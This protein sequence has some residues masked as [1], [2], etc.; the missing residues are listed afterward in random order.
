MRSVTLLKVIMLSVVIFRDIML[1][2]ERLNVVILSVV[3]PSVAASQARTSPKFRLKGE[4]P[5][6]RPQESGRIY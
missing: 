2:V 4:R 3:M 1:N 5:N 6:P